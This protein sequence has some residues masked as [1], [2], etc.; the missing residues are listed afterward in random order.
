MINFFWYHDANG[1][2]NSLGWVKS[3]SDRTAVWTFFESRHQTR[4]PFLILNLTRDELDEFFEEN[5]WIK[6]EELPEF[7]S[8][9]RELFHR[10]EVAYLEKEFI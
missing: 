4:I 3:S 10:A 2:G 7:L 5:Q 8:E 9:Y 1:Q 6:I